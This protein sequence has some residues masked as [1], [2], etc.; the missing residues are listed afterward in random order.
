MTL[1]IKSRCHVGSTFIRSVKM[2]KFE[3]SYATQCISTGAQF[4]AHYFCKLTLVHDVTP[5]THN[6]SPTCHAVTI[7]NEIASLSTNRYR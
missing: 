5:P 6:I 7:V 3:N 4:R 2:R 1:N